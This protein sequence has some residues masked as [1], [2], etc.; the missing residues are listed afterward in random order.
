MSTEIL[1]E[2][3]RYNLGFAY[4]NVNSPTLGMLLLLPENQQRLEFERKGERTISGFRCAE[5]AFRELRDATVVRDHGG[6]VH[7]HGHF[8]IDA[9]RGAVFRTE[10][11]YDLASNSAEDPEDRK[12]GSVT[13]EYGRAPWIDVLVPESMKELY[14]LGPTRIEG[15]ARYSKYREFTVTTNETAT[16]PPQR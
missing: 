1:K 4:R 5:V 15:T 13:T 16:I 9:T 2:G 11:E 12:S 8:W 10:V 6:D 7:S 14:R 3:S